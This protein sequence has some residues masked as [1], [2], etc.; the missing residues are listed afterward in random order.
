MPKSI[1]S[2][3][4]FRDSDVLHPFLEIGLPI[5]ADLFRFFGQVRERRVVVTICQRDGEI[6]MIFPAVLS[7]KLSWNHLIFKIDILDIRFL[8]I[9]ASSFRES[10]PSDDAFT[11]MIQDFKVS[12]FLSFRE[13]AVLSFEA[14]KESYMEDNHVV[15]VSK[16][17]RLLRLAVIYGANASGKTN[18]LE[19][20][21]RLRSFWFEKKKDIDEPTGFVPFLLDIET[22]KAPSKF[23]LR[24]WVDD[25]KYWY[26][27]EV[28][29][30][31]VHTEKLYYY[32]SVQPTMLFS[33]NLEN[34]QS[35]IRF[36]AQAVK[37]TSAV[38]EEIT[39][40]CLPNMS[41][42]AARNRVNCSLPIIDSA[43]DWMKTVMMPIVEP[44]SEMFQ[45]AGTKMQ[46]SEELKDYILR[47]LRRADTNITNINVEK[48]NVQ[49]PS[50]LRNAIVE[51]KDMPDSTKEKLLGENSLSRM[52]AVIEHTV[53][54][55]RGEEKYYLPI[56]AQSAGTQRALG[57]ETALYRAMIDERFLFVD[58]LESSLH[59]DVLML[60]IKEFL[61]K[62]GRSQLVFTTHY[63]PLLNTVDHDLLRKDSVRFT[64]KDST[65]NTVLFPLTDIRGLNKI[66]SFQRSYRSGLF[67]ALP[68]IEL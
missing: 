44:D 47:F 7:V 46:E 30:K 22:P 57:L 19:G 61:E 12:N 21:E 25:V 60:V 58:E 52:R 8:F 4:L 66:S 62:R 43:K 10:I 35:V 15:E 11:A 41:F 68:Q 40:K 42:F 5:Y 18:L 6:E 31:Q 3:I 67:G 39:L 17:V 2:Q 27:L 64:E 20:L 65:G 54:N 1:V 49:L 28:D 53:R 34:G 59:P 45:Y 9:F 38:A 55:L 24:F 26:Q 33:R 63:D 32:K 29:Q 23:E 51:D 16:D 14:A 56:E 48:E 37:V 50:Y 13:E 36:N